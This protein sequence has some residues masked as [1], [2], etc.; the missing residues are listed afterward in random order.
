MSP[1]YGSK[2]QVMQVLNVLGHTSFEAVPEIVS[3]LFQDV[4]HAVPPHKMI[5]G[6]FHF[7]ENHQHWYIVE[8][9]DQN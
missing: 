5:N 2:H 3:C 8:I 9:Q 1:Y 6:G 4:Q 7:G